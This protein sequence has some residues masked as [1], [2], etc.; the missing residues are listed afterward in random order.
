M[1]VNK[2][3]MWDADK[4]QFTNSQEANPLMQRKYRKGWEL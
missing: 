2:K 1:R 4:M 3:L